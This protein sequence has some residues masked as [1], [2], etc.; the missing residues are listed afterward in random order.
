MLKFDG[1]FKWHMLVQRSHC[2]LVL[3]TVI[4]AS[5]LLHTVHPHFCTKLKQQQGT[6]LA[7]SAETVNTCQPVLNFHKVLL[8]LPCG[9]RCCISLQ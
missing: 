1:T 4:C 8:I 5:C 6:V 7:G 2:K 3:G 9:L